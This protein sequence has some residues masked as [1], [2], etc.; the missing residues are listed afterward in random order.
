MKNARLKNWILTDGSVVP[1][2]ELYEGDRVICQLACT[3]DL[4]ALDLITKIN[5]VVELIRFD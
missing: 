5:T 3:S 1:M 4:A 2:V